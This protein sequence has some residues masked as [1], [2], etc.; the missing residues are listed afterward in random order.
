MV[1]KPHHFFHVLILVL[2]FC[3]CACSESDSINV[4]GSSASTAVPAADLVL[5]NSQIYTMDASRNWADSVAVREGRIVYVGDREGI[6][7]Y[8]G[9]K[10]RQVDLAG[11]MLLPSFQDIH[12][13][14][15]AGGKN[16]LGCP[17]YDLGTLE[18]VLE[19]IAGCVEA[20]PDAPFIE[21]NGWNWGMF[22]GSDGPRKELL[23]E[24]DNSRPLIIG[25]ADGHTL[26]LNSSALE[27]A[28]IT[29]DTPEPEG[30]EIGRD[31]QTGELTGALLEGPAMNLIVQELPRAS[32]GQ[33]MDRL[34]Y[35]QNYLHS[36]GITAMQ[37]AIVELSGNG[38]YR[39]LDAYQAMRDSGE[40]KLR[41]VAALY[42]E[43]GAGL[44]QI[45][46]IKAARAKYSGGRLQAG[47]VKFWADGILETRTAK[48]LE[49]YTDQ[50]DTDGILMVP[51]E[52]ML[53]GIPALDALGFQ[54]HI[55]AIGDGTVRVALDALEAARQANGVRDSRHLTAH[56][57]LVHNDDMGRF[58]ELDVIAGFSPY[59]AYNEE[60]IAVINPPQ[61]GPERMAQMYPINRI[62]SSGAR[63]AFGSDWYVA[64]ADPL[65]GIETAVTR[66]SPH[67][68]DPM[69]VFLPDERITLDEAIAGYTINAAFA[70]FLDGDTGSIEVGKYA[71]LV[72]LEKNLFDLEASAISDAAVVATLMEGEV[73]YGGL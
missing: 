70:N 5:T 48:L 33:Q 67:D 21:G 19:T 47:T 68:N 43:P 31:P 30:G 71:D 40:L 20:E 4:Q 28:G 63:V 22:V 27:F 44:N 52:E 11:K 55:H 57:Q 35:A 10:T 51:L 36:L 6:A 59:W 73:V 9:D 7:D 41:V 14:P 72:V 26:W 54:L 25:D 60:Y 1:H 34:R 45:D 64:S 32:V 37:D 39:S 56:T 18:A 53:T 66:V 15:V 3:L 61:L 29:K 23:D 13:H 50:P 46:A 62:A 42:W 2:V 8:V 58:S 69:P 17:L 49:P 24:I 16:Y 12:I 38:V 65:L